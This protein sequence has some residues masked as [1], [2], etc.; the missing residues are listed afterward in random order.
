MV[1]GGVG[2]RPIAFDVEGKRSGQE[3]S[4]EEEVVDTELR[5]KLASSHVPYFRDTDPSMAGVKTV[6]N[7][8][9]HVVSALLMIV[10]LSVSPLWSTRGWTLGATLLGAGL[11]AVFVEFNSGL[12]HIVFDNEKLNGIPVLGT[13]TRDFQIHHL[14]P[15]KLTKVSVCSHLQTVHLPGLAI[16]GWQ[17]LCSRGC[18][19]LRPFW[20]FTM[21]WLHLMYMTHRWAHTPASQ[22]HSFVRWGQRNR[23]LLS[24][25]QHLAHH[26][27][28]D[29]NYSL[30]T[31]WSNLVLNM[32]VRWLRA[33]SLLYVA[34]FL[35]YSCSPALLYLSGVVG[36]V[37]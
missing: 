17:V 31:G 19:S 6:A 20:C 26:R 15:A 24:T 10:W 8:P 5:K 33:D 4:T 36:V 27:T 14:Q 23:L 30:F 2:F 21:A 29:C 28:Y 35:L 11:A 12:F 16:F 37:A 22:L 25:G 7:K 3:R 32:A 34:A 13:L 18:D 9:N 1:P